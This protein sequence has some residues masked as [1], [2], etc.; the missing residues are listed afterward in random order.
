MTDS[1]AARPCPLTL[2]CQTEKDFGDTS[3]GRS[4]H[5]D[6]DLYISL[7]IIRTEYTGRHENN[8]SVHA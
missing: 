4:H 2:E 3:P 5:S 1:P 7:A 8:V 6:T